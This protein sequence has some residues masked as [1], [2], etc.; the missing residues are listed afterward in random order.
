[1][2]GIKSGFYFGTN[3]LHPR[4]VG[5]EYF[6]AKGHFHEQRDHIEYY[7]SMSERV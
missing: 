2:R 7:W 3:Y 6:M 1:M 4:K 5:D